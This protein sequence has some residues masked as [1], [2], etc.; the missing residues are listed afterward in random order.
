V[1]AE[2][3]T[4]SGSEIQMILDRLDR[5]DRRLD[6]AL[7]AKATHDEAL[8]HGAKAID[9]LRLA[10]AAKVDRASCQAM[11]ARME[12]SSEKAADSRQGWART[13]IPPFLAAALAVAGS[14][15]LRQIGG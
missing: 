8:K 5:I 4:V 3:T 15:L 9:E 13:L 14:L 1:N 12:A 11:H 10:C 2:A 7:D 6:I